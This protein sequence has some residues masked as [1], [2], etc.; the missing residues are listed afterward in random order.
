MAENVSLSPWYAARLESAFTNRTSSPRSMA[1][2]PRSQSVQQRAESLD[3]A[4]VERRVIADVPAEEVNV[5]HPRVF[6]VLI[7]EQSA[8]VGLPQLIAAPRGAA[9]EFHAVLAQRPLDTVAQVLVGLPQDEREGV[10]AA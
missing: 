1:P 8:Q 10:V 7:A 2:A 6:A 4:D 9:P 3:T 5:I